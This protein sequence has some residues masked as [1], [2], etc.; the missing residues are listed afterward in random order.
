MIL[1]LV[2]GWRNIDCDKK[3]DSI[4]LDLIPCFCREKAA[5][6]Q[7]LKYDFIH[8]IIKFKFDGLV[9]SQKIPFSVMPADPGSDLPRTGYGVREEYSLFKQLQTICS[10]VFTGVTT[11]YESIEY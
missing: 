1:S 4:R 9:K 11:F 3:P 10:P 5:T 6:L 2:D 7:S 8:G